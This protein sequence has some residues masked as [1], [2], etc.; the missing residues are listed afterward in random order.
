MKLRR[1]IINILNKLHIGYFYYS[2]K[3]L[4]I[5]NCNKKSPTSVNLLEYKKL[6]RENKGTS[7]A[8]DNKNENKKV[9]DLDIIMPIYNGEKY[10]DECLKSIFQQESSYKF[11]LIVIDNGS[12]DKSQNIYNKYSSK[13]TIITLTE[14]KGI[15]RARNIGL[16]KSNAKYLMFVDSDDFLPLNAID[17]LLHKAFATDADVVYGNFCKVDEKN[18][19]LENTNY[20]KHSS[21]ERYLIP[22][23]AWGKVFKS[24]LFK[25]IKFPDG[26]WFEDSVMQMI[27]YRLAKLIEFVPNCV[28]YYRINKKSL[29]NKALYDEKSI[30]TI[31]IFLQLLDDRKK[32]NIKLDQDFYEYFLL[33]CVIS[34]NRLFLL[35]KELLE[36]SFSILCIIKKNFFND[37]KT[38]NKKY[39]DLELALTKN[40]IKLFKLY[41]LHFG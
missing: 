30:D 38:K 7:F 41:S 9:Y 6:S 18:K 33:H 13:A 29:S 20:R 8:L 36:Q 17:I 10:L 15:S 24:E 31:L 25:N 11:R 32:F 28:Y 34:Y 2:F 12:T 26:Y 35:K 27:V 40:N 16:Q 1:H 14:N 4:F 5:K 21:Q 39:Y 19:I 3:K 37:F 23:F 22:G